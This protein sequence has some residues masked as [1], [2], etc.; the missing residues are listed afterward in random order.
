MKFVQRSC[1]L[2]IF[3]HRW[4]GEYWSTK[5]GMLAYAGGLLIGIAFGVVTVQL[6]RALKWRGLAQPPQ[7]L[8]LSVAM[9]Y[10]CFYAANGPGEARPSSIMLGFRTLAN[11]D[12]MA[13]TKYLGPNA[14]GVS[15]P[16]AVVCFGL[17][18]A[19]TSRWDMT[20]NT[21]ASSKFDTFWDTLSFAMNGLV[22]FFAGVSAVNF[23]IRSSEVW[24]PGGAFS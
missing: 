16:I 13:K 9:A 14:G 23:F 6:L 18:G 17:F 10:L 1:N 22:F 8:S 5:R 24:H 21:A 12:G 19:A 20:V 3:F 15:G 2:T 11:V 4:P 7:E